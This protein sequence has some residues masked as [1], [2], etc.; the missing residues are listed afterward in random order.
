MRCDRTS[1]PARFHGVIRMRQ[2]IPGAALYAKVRAHATSATFLLNN[3][4]GS[5]C[6]LCH[7]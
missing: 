2:I 1:E 4:V 7:L 5:K 6:L 3:A